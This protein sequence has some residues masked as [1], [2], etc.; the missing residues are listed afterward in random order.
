M[1]KCK[2]EHIRDIENIR[3]RKSYALWLGTDLYQFTYNGICRNCTC[4]VEKIDDVVDEGVVAYL[5]QTLKEEK[6]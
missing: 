6:S 3:I 5:S 4:Y 2:H 1:F